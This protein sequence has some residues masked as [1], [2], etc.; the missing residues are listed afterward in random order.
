MSIGNCTFE[1]E[2]ITS[3]F[4]SLDLIQI[5]PGSITYSYFINALYC[6]KHILDTNRDIFSRKKQTIEELNSDKQKLV[7]VINQIVS[8]IEDMKE[9]VKN[10]I[11]NL[12][13]SEQDKQW[14]ILQVA[15]DDFVSINEW[16]ASISKQVFE[17]FKYGQKKRI[18]T[19][20]SILEI[21]FHQINLAIFLKN[22]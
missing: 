20:R 10:E 13:S 12:D 7:Y 14:E 4:P 19:F 6:I 8:V 15:I 16:L 22:I 21:A 18:I 1:F 11:N 17:D 9:N 3:T 2:D 5:I